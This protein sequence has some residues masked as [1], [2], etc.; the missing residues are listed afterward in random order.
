MGEEWLAS[1]PGRFAPEER[2]VVSMLDW[3]AHSRSGRCGEDENPTVQ[4]NKWGRIDVII[5]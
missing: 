5:Y 3:S 4:V 2:S 1:G